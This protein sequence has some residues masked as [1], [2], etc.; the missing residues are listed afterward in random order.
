MTLLGVE[1]M[2]VF[3]KIHPPARKAFG[4]WRTVIEGATWT[5]PA[6][7]KQ[8]FGTADIVSEQTVFNVGGN[9]YRLI[10]LVD[11]EEQTVLVQHVLTHD[12]YDKGGWNK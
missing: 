9:K 8:A 1:R 5:N 10:A 7:M 2:E 3:G 4:K 11:Y 12:E 6:E